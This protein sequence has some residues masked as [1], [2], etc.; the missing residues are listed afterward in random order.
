[1]ENKLP[2][3]ARPLASQ[4][5][6]KRVALSAASESMAPERCMQS[7]ATTP[8]ARPSMRTRAVRIATP[9]NLG[10]RIVRGQSRFPNTTA[11]RKRPSR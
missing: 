1:M 4:R 5:F 10:P 6:M 9:K 3:A 8:T 2:F 11:S 7:L